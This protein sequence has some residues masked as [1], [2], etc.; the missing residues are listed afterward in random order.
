MGDFFTVENAKAIATTV[1]T[2]IVFGAVFVV[3]INKFIKQPY[4]YKLMMQFNF[5]LSCQMTRFI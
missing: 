4:I 5:F 1:G 2:I 3:T